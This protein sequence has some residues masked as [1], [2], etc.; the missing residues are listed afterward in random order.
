MSKRGDPAAYTITL[1][2][3]Y[4]GKILSEVPRTDL[5]EYIK[6]LNSIEL[7]PGS[8]GAAQLQDLKENYQKL[9]N[10]EPPKEKVAAP[11]SKPPPSKGFRKA[12][13]K[14]VYLKVAITGPS[15]SGKTMSALRMARGIVGLKGR[16]A[17]ID[18]ENDAAS[19]YSGQIPLGGSI[20]IDFD[21]QNMEPPF[22]VS[23]YIQMI[24]LAVSEGYDALVV[25]SMSHAWKELLDK[26]E[27]M[28][29]RGGNQYTNWAPISKEHTQFLNALLHSKIHIIGCMRS[30]QDYVL[31]KN[32][33]GKQT[34]IKVGMAPVQREGMEY[35]FTVVF[36]LGMDNHWQ[37]SKDR[38][39][40]F[41]NTNDLIT[42]K[43][44][45]QLMAWRASGAVES[46]LEY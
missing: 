18:T 10:A 7:A 6:M 15:G 13:K 43:T 11:A 8:E 39:S 35:E 34:P 29:S 32:D 27:A 37:V 12:E 3:K 4:K 40:M 26:K 31:E 25:D 36:D 16:I 19:L 20:P 45:E 9:Y 2:K 14:A 17:L 22:L 44:G 30:K 5:D 38:T 23:K 41:K 42:E 28:D 33:K 21:T 46:E 24:N 1:G